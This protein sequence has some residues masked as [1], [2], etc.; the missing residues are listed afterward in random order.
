MH[1][2][3][4]PF[5]AGE[6]YTGGDPMIDTTL[7]DGVLRLGP[8]PESQ[9]LAAVPL[10]VQ[11]EIVGALVLLKLFDHKPILRAEDREDLRRRH[12]AADPRPAR[13]NHRGR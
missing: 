1:D 10:R 8:T 5:F 6:T 12:G 3:M 9:V 2:E 11:N 13:R 7:T 4:D